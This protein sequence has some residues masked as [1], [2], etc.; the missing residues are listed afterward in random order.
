MEA[1]FQE[2]FDIIEDR[3]QR[4]H[5][6]YRILRIVTFA[7]GVFLI[8]SILTISALLDNIADYFVIIATFFLISGIGTIIA[9]TYAILTLRRIMQQEKVGEMRS[10]YFAMHLVEPFMQMFFLVVMIPTVV[11]LDA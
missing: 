1:K 7:L 4:I 11:V 3:L 10:Y 8:L 9:K 2:S 6:S 5:S